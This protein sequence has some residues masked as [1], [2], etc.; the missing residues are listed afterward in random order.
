[1][2]DDPIDYEEFI[3][4]M[5]EFVPTIPDEV[6]TYYLNKTGFSCS[7]IKIKRLIALATQ[8][9]ISDIA[10]D[11]LQYCKIRLQGSSR[12]KT[13]KDKALVLTMDDLSL[14]LKEYGINI[15][16]PDYYAE[17]IPQTN[18]MAPVVLQQ[19]QQS[20]LQQQ[21]EKEKLLQ[22]QQQQQQI[23]Q[24][25]T[26]TTTTSTAPTDNAVVTSKSNGANVK[27]LKTN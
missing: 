23:L 24:N 1:M 8:K 16:K 12:E 22:Q 5:E 27:K 25:P 13:R 17:N 11:S 4:S 15:R 18:L 21:K 2:D 14:A 7:D 10:N 6:I 19:Q 9:F 26:E 20:L 3:N